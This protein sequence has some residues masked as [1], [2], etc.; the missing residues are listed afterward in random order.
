[1]H[2][3]IVIVLLTLNTLSIGVMCLRLNTY[4]LDHHTYENK[5]T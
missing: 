2:I 5:E 1:M 3:Y 4:P